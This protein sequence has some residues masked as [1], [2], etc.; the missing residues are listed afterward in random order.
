MSTTLL[1]ANHNVIFRIPIYQ[2]HFLNVGNT[3]KGRVLNTVLKVKDIL[4]KLDFIWPWRSGIFGCYTST[5]HS[6][7]VWS[8]FIKNFLSLDAYK[9]KEWHACKHC[10]KHDL[11]GRG[12]NV[13][14]MRHTD[15]SSQAE[16]KLWDHFKNVLYYQAKIEITHK[17][18]ELETFQRKLWDV[19]RKRHILHFS[20][21]RSNDADCVNTCVA[22]VRFQWFQLAPPFLYR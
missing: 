22:K 2:Y 12:N 19:K 4:W 10:Q 18:E 21:C 7:K 8:E 6:Y 9:Q 15:K 5:L 11:F 14:S 13:C 20:L 1:D 3:N 17:S 16:W